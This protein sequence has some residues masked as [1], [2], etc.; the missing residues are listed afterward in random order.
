[1]DWKNMMDWA[2]G[3]TG[4]VTTVL[5]VFLGGKALRLNRVDAARTDVAVA[6]LNGDKEE[7]ER[8]SSTL[9][10][11]ESQITEQTGKIDNLTS[12]V[13]QLEA[14]VRD[15]LN[16]N[17]NSAMLLEEIDLRRP[18][19]AS[20]NETMLKMAIKQLRSAHAAHG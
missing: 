12:K 13:N 11:L 4:L 7:A 20:A 3:I 16:I 14:D 5:L 19:L 8:T 2:N 9:K 15:L 6:E 10:R 17:V 18:E 1:M